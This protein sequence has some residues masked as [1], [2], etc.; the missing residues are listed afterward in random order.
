MNG[1]RIIKGQVALAKYLGVSQ[2]TVSS[3]HKEGKFEG[4]FFRIGR[5]ISY[6]L[7]AIEKKFRG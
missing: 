6:D 7:D 5:V 3:W 1:D 2:P 4:C